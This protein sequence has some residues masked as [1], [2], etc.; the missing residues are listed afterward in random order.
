[1]QSIRVDEGASHLTGRSTTNIIRLDMAELS[2]LLTVLQYQTVRHP[3]HLNKPEFGA[4]AQ[5][6]QCESKYWLASANEC[7]LND[8]IT[9]PVSYT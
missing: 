1:V 5:D 8:M 6:E 4:A 2:A 3:V 7:G 9:E